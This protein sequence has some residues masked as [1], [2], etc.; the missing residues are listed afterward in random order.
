MQVFAGAA[1]AQFQVEGV[2]Q[3]ALLGVG[4]PGHVESQVRECVQQGLVGGEGRGGGGGQ[5]GQAG[6]VGLQLPAQGGVFGAD[7]V[8]ELPLGVLIVIAVAAGSTGE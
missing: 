2:E 5:L 7:G 6:P 4:E 1:V 8:A 3:A